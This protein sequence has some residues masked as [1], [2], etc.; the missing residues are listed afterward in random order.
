MLYLLL[1]R[2]LVRNAAAPPLNLLLLSPQPTINWWLKALK[3]VETPVGAEG[4]CV[5][6]GTPTLKAK[7]LD[8]INDHQVA[9]GKRLRS[10]DVQ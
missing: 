6:T 5:P 3:V 8:G 10:L 2:N 7:V 1:R 4:G 9:V